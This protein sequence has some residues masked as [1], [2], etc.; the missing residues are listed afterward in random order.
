MASIV[1]ICNL[2]L[3][4][5]AGNLITDIAENSV[6]ARLCSANF[7]LARDAV[8]EDR[9]WT[10]ATTRVRLVP[11]TPL[12]TDLASKFK[13]PTE[14]LRILKASAS[15]QFDDYLRWYVERGYILA[16]TGV[17]F[18]KYIARIVDTEQFSSNFVQAFA[19]RLASDIAIPLTES[20]SMQKAMW[21][22]Y[23]I[24]LKSA[25]AT[26][27]MQGKSEEFRSTKLVRARV[28]GVSG[29]VAGPYV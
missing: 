2:S 16:E 17:L 3:G 25:A 7:D 15:M 11:V 13:V 6:E 18:V 29:N 5:L 12:P 23:E 10:F 14:S 20:L 24:K 21:Q 1:D 8:L 22:L 4:W 28:V 26:D 9:A 27:G 19:A